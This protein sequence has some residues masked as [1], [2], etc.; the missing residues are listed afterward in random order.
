MIRELGYEFDDWWS[1]ESLEEEAQ[2]P[3]KYKIPFNLRG[4]PDGPVPN[5]P[6]QW[7]GL[8]WRPQTKKWMSRGGKHLDARNASFGK[9]S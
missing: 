6:K 2:L 7:R 1:D 9:K 4:P 5:G 3:A 8:D